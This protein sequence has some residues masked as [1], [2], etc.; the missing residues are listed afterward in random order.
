MDIRTLLRASA[1]AL[2]VTLAQNVAAEGAADPTIIVIGRAAS[3][4]AEERAIKTPGGTDIVSH[5]ARF[6]RRA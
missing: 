6:C 3:D 5:R 2:C 4:E 1:C